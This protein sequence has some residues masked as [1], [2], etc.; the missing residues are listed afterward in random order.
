[1][2]DVETTEPARD[3]SALA[4]AVIA[5][6]DATYD[7]VYVSYDDKFTR[8]QIAALVRGDSE[9][10]WSD[11]MDWE[12]DSRYE[13]CKVIIEQEAA[14]V[15]RNWE[16][17]DASDDGQDTEPYT[18]EPD[19][20][21][22]VNGDRVN[23]ISASRLEVGDT[24][25]DPAYD[26]PGDEWHT[27]D[28]VGTR[29]ATVHVYTPT[30]VPDY[31]DVLNDLLGGGEHWDRVRE[32]IEERDSGKWPQELA[33]NSG[34]VLLRIAI[35][36]IDED[37]AYDN[38]QVEAAGVLERLGLDA[39]E[40]NLR[41]VQYVLDNA[42]PEY[43]VLMGYWVFGAEVR[44]LFDLPVEADTMIEIDGPHLYLGNPFAGSGFVT[45]HALHATVT[46]RRDE[47]RTDSDAF[48][49]A[50]DEVYGG[51]SPSEFEAD[52]RV[53]SEQDATNAAQK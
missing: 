49:Y 39:D 25:H 34:R 48:G 3:S 43:S 29:D 32:A 28:S 27:A 16:G 37:H 10:L 44:Q 35:D 14:Q 20:G 21:L 30:A 6:L 22:H 31:T 7:L 19:Y 18:F 33:D 40:H 17:Q 46:V 8:E 38:E 51:L 2:T 26:E 23:L 15:V 13:S 11:T 53:R 45:E 12:S 52:L 47:L 5:A 42:S 41:E 1:M 24:F 50:L 4:D 9:K 36:S